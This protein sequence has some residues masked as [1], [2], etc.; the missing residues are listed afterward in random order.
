MDLAAML[1]YR[2]GIVPESLETI[3]ADIPDESAPQEEALSGP[4]GS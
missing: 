2:K 3:L 4:L 1:Q